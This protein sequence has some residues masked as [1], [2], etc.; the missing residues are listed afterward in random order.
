MRYN[1]EK[2]LSKQQKIQM[3]LDGSNYTQEEEEDNQAKR[4][5]EMNTL[6]GEDNTMTPNKKNNKKNND[7]YDRIPH[8][9][10]TPS[11]QQRTVK[12]SPRTKRVSPHTK[13]GGKRRTKSKKRS[14]K[15]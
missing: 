13:R 3:K 7:N 9:N 14:Q 5:A 12:F 4:N 15:I 10:W 1:R 8:H 2:M 6:L 11:K